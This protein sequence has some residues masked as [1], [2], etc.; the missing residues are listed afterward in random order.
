MDL[1][2]FIKRRLQWETKGLVYL[3]MFNRKQEMGCVFSSLPTD[4][5]K[6]KQWKRMFES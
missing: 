4:A 3:K 2:S 5:N 6:H 1:I